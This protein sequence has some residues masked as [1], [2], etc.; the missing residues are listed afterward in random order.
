MTN[1]IIQSDDVAWVRHRIEGTGIPVFAVVSRF[2]GGD[3]VADLAWDYN[4]YPEQ[5]EAAIRYALNHTDFD[6]SDQLTDDQH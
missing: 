5:I 6:G 2:M 3:S 4:L 1:G